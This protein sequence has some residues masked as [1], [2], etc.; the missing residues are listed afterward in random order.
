MYTIVT[1]T[2]VKSPSEHIQS[3]GLLNTVAQNR[4]PKQVD[5]NPSLSYTVNYEGERSLNTVVVKNGRLYTIKLDYAD[6]NTLKTSRP[7]YDSL[8]GSFKFL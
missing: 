4:V 7:D 3:S 8:V 2:T 5:G 6:D 1:E